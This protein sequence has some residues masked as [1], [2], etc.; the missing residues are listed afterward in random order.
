[1]AIFYRML[2]VALSASLLVVPMN[3]SAAQKR[4]PTK[5]EKS[6]AG[7]YRCASYNVSGSG[8]GNCRLMPPLVLKK[9]GTYA[10]SSEKG[11]FAV[12]RKGKLSLSASKLRGEGVIS[13]DKLTFTFTYSYRGWKHTLSYRKELGARANVAPVSP[14]VPG[15]QEAKTTAQPERLEI[16]VQLVLQYPAKDSGL[17]GITTIELVP[18][19]SDVKM[20]SYKPTT[21][22]VYDGDRTIV[23][24]FYKATNM[25]L[26][27]T[28]YKVYANTG[29]AQTEVGA[30]DL[31]KTTTEIKAVIMVNIA[32]GDAPRPAEQVDVSQST[33]PEIVVEIDVVAPEKNSA[34]GSIN[35]ITLVP[36]GEDP[37]TATYKPTALA[38]WDGDKTVVGSFH[39]ATNQVRTGS[40]Y[41][42]YLDTI[43]LTKIGSLDLKEVKE[44]PLKR[45]YPFSF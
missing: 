35:F 1:M 28:V 14:V 32:A 20:A 31:T 42:V 23:G 10:M 30:L 4:V 25:P 45:E 21:I 39:K 12:T 13:R 26:N 11:T 40:A 38:V 22:A 36:Q 3:I 44:G 7:L 6:L 2:F 24:S 43:S 33:A 37:V 27:G 34:L 9:D 19:G 41:D 8:G 15:T 29:F 5:M 18:E 17:G 16:P